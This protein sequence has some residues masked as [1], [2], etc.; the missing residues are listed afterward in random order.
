[1]Q[2]KTDLLGKPRYVETK[3]DIQP[4]FESFL[5]VLGTEMKEDKERFFPKGINSISFTFEVSELINV[6]I[7]IEGVKVEAAY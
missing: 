5:S 1:M 6:G 7:T 4:I 3:K 2:D